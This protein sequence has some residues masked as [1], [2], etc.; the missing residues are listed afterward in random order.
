MVTFI[1]QR[2]INS[3][4]I[5]LASF[6]LYLLFLILFSTFLGMMYLRQSMPFVRAAATADR[7]PPHVDKPVIAAAT[8]AGDSKLSF[9]KAVQTLQMSRIGQRKH[10]NKKAFSGCTMST[11]FSDIPLCLVEILLTA[12]LVLQLGQ[13]AWE[14]LAL[15]LRY[16]REMENW[17]NLLVYTFTITSLTFES[18]IEVHKIVSS[19]GIC[20]AWLELIFM[21]GRYPSLGG[22]FS[23][24]FYSITKRI[25]QSALAFLIMVIAFGFAFFIINYGNEGEQ[26]QN[27]GKSL[28][29]IFVMVLGEFEF[30][31]LYDK[32]D[33]SSTTTLVFTMLLLIG[34]PYVLY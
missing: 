7:C 16:F 34:E 29:K 22:R 28:L 18:N 14:C 12:S 10:Q 32:T 23:I 6:F 5:F 27:P 30:D 19:F 2:W 15:G 13:E 3:K 11:N 31:N 21:L 4:S 17:C 24:M 26:F 20:L 1:Q 8:M 25:V 9:V 33:S